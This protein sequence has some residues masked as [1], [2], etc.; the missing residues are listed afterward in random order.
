M[1]RGTRKRLVEVAGDLFYRFGF[2]AVG[3]DRILGEVGITKTAFYKHFESKD[4]LILA[5]LDHRD[6]QDIAQAVGHM[7]SHG[8]DDPRSQILAF[9]DLMA[10]WFSEP[11]F[12]GCLFMNA[13]TEFAS[14]LDPIHR[15][16]AAHGD[17]LSQEFLLRA[18]AARLP[19]PHAAAR[20]LLLLL[21][22]AIVARHAGGMVDAALLAR[23]AAAALLDVRTGGGKSAARRSRVDPP[24]ATPPVRRRRSSA[25][26]R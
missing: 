12:R 15:A 14:P 10:E 1:L 2:Q 22:G 23:S 26:R 3:L 13:A 24:R 4:D 9:F 6:R 19:D 25:R 20:Q 18:Q 21:N 17:H 8:G 11:D 7:R 16:A 5:V